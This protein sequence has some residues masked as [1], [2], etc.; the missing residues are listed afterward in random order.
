LSWIYSLKVQGKTN[1]QKME[2]I[3]NTQV[4]VHKGRPH[5][6][7]EKLTPSSLVRKM[8]ALD[9]LLPPSDCGRPLWT[10]P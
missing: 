4:A 9:N 3:R 8:S 1:V 2:P 6:N 10:A 5:K 7:R